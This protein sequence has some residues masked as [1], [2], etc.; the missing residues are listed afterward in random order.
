MTFFRV[1]MDI[2]PI[3][4]NLTLNLSHTLAHPLLRV[5][6]FLVIMSDFMLGLVEKFEIA[7]FYGDLG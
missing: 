4:A 1:K 7:D 6:K 2:R 5:G 3:F